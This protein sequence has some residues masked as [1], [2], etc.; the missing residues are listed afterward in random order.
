MKKAILIIFILM[1]LLSMVT[2][3]AAADE[4][5]APNPPLLTE[6]EQAWYTGPTAQDIWDRM[7]ENQQSAL[8]KEDFEYDGS[9]DGSIDSAAHDLSIQGA[10]LM[11]TFEVLLVGKGVIF[12]YIMPDTIINTLANV[13]MPIG[14]VIFLI[15]WCLG[16]AKKSSSLELY[17][18]KGIVNAMLTLFAGIMILM[19]CPQILRLITYVADGLT[20]EVLK[21]STVSV[22]EIADA[23]GG[24]IGSFESFKN[25][26]PIIGFFISLF[27]FIM[28]QYKM[29]GFYIVFGITTAIMTITLALRQIKLAIFTGIAPAFIALAGNDDTKKYAMNFLGRFA[30]LAFQ[31]TLI[32]AVY[33]AFKVTMAGWITAGIDSVNFAGATLVGGIAL[34]SQCMAMSKTEK[35]F[36]PMFS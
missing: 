33:G 19:I 10:E 17:E 34:I 8:K 7:D 9:S 30:L 13:F 36:A 22:N 31:V 16:L 1:I 23:V 28:A 11:Q 18:G 3:T 14:I 20:V 29:I 4:T 26:T 25:N 2:L 24:K 12:G 21:S 27:N 32:A 15:M 35:M 5:P 6:E